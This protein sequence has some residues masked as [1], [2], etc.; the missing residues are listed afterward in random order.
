MAKSRVAPLKPVTIPRLELTAAL[1]SVKTSSILQR[2]LEYDQITE[3]Y[4][5]DSKVVFG[6]IN[7]D[8]RR[9]H[10][11]VANRVQQI[12]DHTLPNQWKYVETDQKPAD[13]ATRGQNVQNLIETSRWWNGREFLWKPLE[14][15]SSLD[16]GEPMC[17]SP[18]DL[19]VKKISAMTTQTRE[20]FSLPDR[21][22]Y[23]S[24]WHKAKQAVAVCLGLQ[25][26]YRTG[27]EGQDMVITK[28]S[29]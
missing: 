14:D 2:E 24:S 15:Q 18:D 9:F 23:F 13:D 22:K 4:W 26:K 5:T 3:M 25:R 27:S 7:N 29:R 21:V 8:A 11:F 16:G 19:K 10:V 12:R 6:Y 28:E 20:C 17:I 1:V